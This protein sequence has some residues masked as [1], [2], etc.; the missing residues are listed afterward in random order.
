MSTWSL[1]TR[2][3]DTYIDSRHINSFAFNELNQWHAVGIREQGFDSFL[4]S[5]RLCRFTFLY[6]YRAFQRFRKFGLISSSGNL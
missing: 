1:S 6:F 4:V 5:N 3:D 2:Q